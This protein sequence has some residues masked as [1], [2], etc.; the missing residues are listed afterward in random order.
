M[1]NNVAF[2]LRR[3]SCAH[4][5]SV[6]QKG[7]QRAQR[8]FTS[9]LASVKYNNRLEHEED[10]RSDPPVCRIERV[11]VDPDDTDKDM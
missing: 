11:I 9:L 6:L 4:S 7:D 1:I 5:L 3:R 8:L 2:R 10:R